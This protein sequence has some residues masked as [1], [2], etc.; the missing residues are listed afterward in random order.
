M[1]S[2]LLS[3]GIVWI[4]WCSILCVQ[5]MCIGHLNSIVEGPEE[6]LQFCLQELN[7]LIFSISPENLRLSLVP[8]SCETLV[9]S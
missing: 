8:V 1:H 7:H 3:H 6:I 2:N 4:M 5:C 9:D